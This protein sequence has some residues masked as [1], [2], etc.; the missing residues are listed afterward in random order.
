MTFPR[1]A[2]VAGAFVIMAAL[3]G[4]VPAQEGPENGEQ[5]SQFTEAQ[6][7]EIGRLVREYLIRNPEVL[8]EAIRALQAR[9][10]EE[11]RAAAEVAL[12][13]NRDALLRNEDSPVGGNPNGNVTIVEFFDYQCGF[14]K[15]AFPEMQAAVEADGNVRVVYKEWPVLGPA[16]VFAAR[17][18][19]ASRAQG[20]YEAFHNALMGFDGQ[21]SNE[22]V[23]QIAASVGL[24]VARL[25][26][27]MQS[28]E[29]DGILRRNHELAQALGIEGTPAFVIGD[30]L[31]PGAIGEQQFRT[32]ID[33]A[34]ESCETEVC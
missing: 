12:R 16:S 3:V 2:A 18:A 29:V 20:K 8:E 7:E 26:E 25:Q 11:R 5:Q 4:P 24:D 34:R 19:L 22:I 6:R 1:F 10:E 9:R 21:L 28:P 23:M 17:A 31:I 30:E 27:D 15:R 32:H 14:C 33:R 13:E